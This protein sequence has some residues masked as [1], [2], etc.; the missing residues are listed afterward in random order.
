M[1]TSVF[2]LT[3]MMIAIIAS[4]QISTFSEKEGLPPV[5]KNEKNFLFADYLQ[6]SVKYPDVSSQWKHG[7]TVII[8][9]VVTASGELNDFTVINSVSYEADREVIRSIKSTKNKWM[10]GSIDG[11]PADMQQEVAV[12]FKLYPEDDFVRFAKKYCQKGNNKLFVKNQPKRALDFYNLG[13]KY[14]PNDMTLLSVRGLCRHKLGDV[15]GA[16]RDLE[17]VSVLAERSGTNFDLEI[18]AGLMENAENITDFESFR[19][20]IE[21]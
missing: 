14:L 7:G 2:L 15:A 20:A 9:F 16:N 6:K 21:K 10:P 19:N 4:G 3:G 18:L 17:R 5:F 8:G 1:K 13:I 11:N 12:V